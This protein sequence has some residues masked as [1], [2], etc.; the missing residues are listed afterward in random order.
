MREPFRREAINKLSG[1]T[2][3]LHWE[4]FELTGRCKSGFSFMHMFCLYLEHQQLIS[5]FP[6]L[7]YYKYAALRKANV[8]AAVFTSE[9]AKTGIKKQR[10]SCRQECTQWREDNQQRRWIS[11]MNKLWSRDDP[12]STDPF[13]RK[14]DHINTR[15]CSSSICH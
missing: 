7:Y 1:S 3:K 9:A 6:V 5:P 8:L 15:T 12:W 11:W 4:L 14:T 13:S 10:R 2:F